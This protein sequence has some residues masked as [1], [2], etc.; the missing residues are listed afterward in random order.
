MT[1]I[2]AIYLQASGFPS[3]S[4]E[5]AFECCREDIGRYSISLSYSSPG[6]DLVAFF[7]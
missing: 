4:S 6:V 7:V 2:D 3:Q 1:K 5:Y